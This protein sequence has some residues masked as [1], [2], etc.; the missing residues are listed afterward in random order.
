MRREVCTQD[1]LGFGRVARLLCV[2]GGFERGPVRRLR[3]RLRQ[4]RPN[5]ARTLGPFVV[6]VRALPRFEQFDQSSVRR[7]G[8][9]S[10]VRGCNRISSTARG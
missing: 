10:G 9:S 8:R 6:I 3:S 2:C 1:A 5:L 4:V 7:H